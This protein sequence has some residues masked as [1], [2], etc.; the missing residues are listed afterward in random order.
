[1][2]GEAALE[3]LLDAIKDNVDPLDAAPGKRGAEDT[4]TGTHC[5][6]F[7]VR[8]VLKVS[9][10]PLLRCTCALCSRSVGRPHRNPRSRIGKW[11]GLS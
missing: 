7:G 5:S 2:Q 1:M 10:T 8:G 11:F 6:N 4:P 9:R 3:S